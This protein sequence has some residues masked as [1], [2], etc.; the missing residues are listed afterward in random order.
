MA[1]VRC[2]FTCRE[3]TPTPG[4]NPTYFA[5][6]F[7]VYDGSEENKEF[8]RYTPAGQIELS[9]INGPY[10]EVGKDYYIDISPA[11]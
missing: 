10:F 5:K 7:P 9:T 11:V 8:F 1:N 3:M 4:E 6:F 2:K